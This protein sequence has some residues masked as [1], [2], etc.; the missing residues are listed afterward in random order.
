MSEGQT[1]IMEDK[2]VLI[3]CLSIRRGQVYST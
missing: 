3:V 1:E 2:V